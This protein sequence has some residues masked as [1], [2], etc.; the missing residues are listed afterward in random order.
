MSPQ[1]SK[2]KKKS[3]LFSEQNRFDAL[4]DIDREETKM[5]LLPLHLV[6]L[7]SLCSKLLRRPK[8]VVPNSNF[9]RTEVVRGGLVRALKEEVFL[10]LF[11]PHECSCL[12]CKG[13]E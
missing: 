6:S 1:L 5:V 7:I 3:G 11:F 13:F 10:F 4:H 2:E 8:R 9:P 12:E